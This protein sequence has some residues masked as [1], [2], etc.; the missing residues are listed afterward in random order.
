MKLL[1]R[2]LDWLR[3]FIDGESPIF[4]RIDSVVVQECFSRSMEKVEVEVADRDFRLE[5]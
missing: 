1:N 2:K 3:I 5:I 4:G